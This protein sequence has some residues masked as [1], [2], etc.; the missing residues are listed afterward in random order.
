MELYFNNKTY[1]INNNI[2]FESFP[3]YEEDAKQ[4]T[5]SNQQFQEQSQAA[6]NT[7]IN[8]PQQV[9]QNNAQTELT[10][11]E[12]PSPEELQKTINTIYSDD[13]LKQKYI[14][15]LN[16]IDTSINVDTSINI[17]DEIET[18]NTLEKGTEILSNIKSITDGKS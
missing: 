15:K 11:K 3:I 7:S 10:N 8:Q 13:T 12:L 1:N 6:K 14:N 16:N 4:D 2:L 5:S 18:I 17:M 9:Q